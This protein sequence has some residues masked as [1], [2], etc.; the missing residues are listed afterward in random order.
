MV[1]TSNHGPMFSTNGP[2]IVLLAVCGD[3]ARVREGAST[4]PHMALHR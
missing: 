2:A 4:S 3:R 1:F